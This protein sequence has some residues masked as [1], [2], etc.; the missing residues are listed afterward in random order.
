MREIREDE[1]IEP[2]SRR[3]LTQQEILRLVQEQRA[4]HSVSPI[5]PAA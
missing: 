5:G 2:A 1:A 4:K 3:K